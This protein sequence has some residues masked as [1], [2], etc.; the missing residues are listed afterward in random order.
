MK[1]IFSI[2]LL[3]S[4]ILLQSQPASAWE[5][6]LRYMRQLDTKKN[7]DRLIRTRECRGCYLKGANLRGYDLSDVKI[8]NAQLDYATW[9]N[10]ERCQPGSI[11]RCKTESEEN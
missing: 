11:G 9:S 5:D 2:L 6:R 8:E 4:I 7:V 3:T 1:A 10:G